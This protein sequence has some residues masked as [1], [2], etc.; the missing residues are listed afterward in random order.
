MFHQLHCL[1]RARSRCL[2]QIRSNL[3]LT[4][5]RRTWLRRG[6]TTSIKNPTEFF[7]IL[8]QISHHW[9]HCFDYLRQ[10]LMC[11]A[12]GTLETV[13]TNGNSKGETMLAGVEGWGMT[14]TCR[15]YKQV[16]DWA[17]EHRF[18]DELGID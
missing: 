11:A 15:D 10:S 2:D 7:Y 1:V 8:P 12:D 18:N 5:P 14:H 9:A 6:F 3:P 16:F 13:H 17:E 4:T